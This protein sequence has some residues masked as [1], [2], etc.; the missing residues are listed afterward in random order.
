MCQVS[1]TSLKEIHHVCPHRLI[2]SEARNERR[3][4]ERSPQRG[5]S[6]PEEAAGIYGVPA[7][8]AGDQDGKVDHRHSLGRETGCRPLG[9]RRVSQG[10]RNP[11]TLSGR[12]G[13][14]QLLQRGN[15]P[16]HALSRSPEDLRSDTSGRN[17]PLV[18]LA[19]NDASILFG[20]PIV[21]E[22]VSSTAGSL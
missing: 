1:Q 8:R 3:N 2:Y 21:I 4:R 19:T 16:L 14:L 7:L 15:L 13:H 20:S 9:A 5:S 11:Q 17:S 10:G 18:L 22:L 6:D 12:P